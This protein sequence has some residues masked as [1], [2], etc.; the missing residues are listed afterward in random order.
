MKQA[1]FQLVLLILFLVGLMAGFVSVR[2][3]LNQL[4]A[5]QVTQSQSLMDLGSTLADLETRLLLL[6]VDL[7]SQAVDM[8][9][10]Q[11]QLSNSESETGSSEGGLPGSVEE[12]VVPP[13]EWPFLLEDDL[14]LKFQGRFSRSDVFL[15]MGGGGVARLVFTD[16]LDPYETPEKRKLA[17]DLLMAYL[18]RHDFVE[19]E[20]VRLVKSGAGDEF[21][22]ERE[23][24][25]HLEKIR[26]EGKSATFREL[27]GGKWVVVDISGI[28]SSAGYDAASSRIASLPAQL[29]TGGTYFGVYAPDHH[30]FGE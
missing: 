9:R 12:Q 29:G 5:N 15:D 14:P 1:H 26:S 27:P 20:I 6:E 11:S 24:L 7:Q 21:S 23:C 10:T 17:E 19:G 30:F 25:T 16:G 3:S 28:T 8:H 13:A 22:T 18:D 2:K 4:R